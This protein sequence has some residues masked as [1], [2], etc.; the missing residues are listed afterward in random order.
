MK[1]LTKTHNRPTR[2]G[3]AAPPEPKAAGSNPAGRANIYRGASPLELPY[4]LSRSPLRRLAPFAWLA[5]LCSLASDFEGL[6]FFLLLPFPFALCEARP[7][8]SP[9]R[10]LARRFAGS[11]RSRG[12]LA[13]LVRVEPRAPVRWSILAAR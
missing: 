12:S 3:R 2:Y 5:S 4:T 8:N 6:L 13:A 9:T 7:S 10:S 11:L 1:F